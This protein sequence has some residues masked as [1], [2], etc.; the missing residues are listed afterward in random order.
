MRSYA[1]KLFDL[2]D[3]RSAWCF[4][5]AEIRYSTHHETLYFHYIVFNTTKYSNVKMNRKKRM[6]LTFQ[7]RI[8]RRLFSTFLVLL[9]IVV[10]IVLLI[11]PFKRK[12][13]SYINVRKGEDRVTFY[14]SIPAA[15]IIIM[16][17]T[18][19]VGRA[20]GLSEGQGASEGE[21]REKEEKD[22]ER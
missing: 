19:L 13:H 21:E 14:H 15:N 11:N 16:R 5:N 18:P 20:G 8:T 10:F 12:S 22:D 7:R 4:T 6:L 9:L 1:M 17:Q 3:D 2:L